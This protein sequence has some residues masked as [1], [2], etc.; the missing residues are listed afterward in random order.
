MAEE[1]KKML[2]VLEETHKGISVLAKAHKTT[3]V[4]YMYNLTIKEL[5]KLK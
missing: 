2:Q 3:I 1:K 5:K 4:G